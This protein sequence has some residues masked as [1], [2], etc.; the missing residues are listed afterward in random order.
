MDIVVTDL[1]LDSLSRR[2]QRFAV[3]CRHHASPLYE[4]LSV[5]VAADPEMLALAARAG[6]VPVPNLFFA[7]AHFLLLRGAEHPVSRFYPSLCEEPHPAENAY[8]AFR[9]SCLE[10][11]AGIRELISQR[12][13]QTNEVRRCA[14]L[15][16]AFGIV[17]DQTEGRPL[18]LVE[19]GASAGLITVH[20]SRRDLCLISLEGQGG[21]YS[22]LELVSFRRGARTDR[23][24][25]RCSSHGDRL[26]W[27]DG[28]FTAG[29]AN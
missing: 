25:A 11:Q 28:D 18:A 5:S 1:P 19:V 12:R 7:A 4:R 3:E 23:V 10:R 13:V 8:P 9:S 2:F 26:E 20:A 21:E 17:S 16:P 22:L 15:L 14:C 6:S 29:G 27:L 24:L